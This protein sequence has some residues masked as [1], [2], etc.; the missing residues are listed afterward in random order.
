MTAI[1]WMTNHYEEM[2]KTK[3]TKIK[4]KRKKNQ[5]IM[6]S[7]ISLEKPKGRH[8]NGRIKKSATGRF[9]LS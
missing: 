2:R 5:S 8:N 4:H 6:N 1:Y 9:I 3:L 7:L